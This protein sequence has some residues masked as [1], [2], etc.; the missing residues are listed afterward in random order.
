MEN[1][2][3]IYADGQSKYI[4]CRVKTYRETAIWPLDTTIIN[5]LYR[6]MNKY[7]CTRNMYTR[8]ERTDETNPSGTQLLLKIFV[9]LKT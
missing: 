7:V 8:F 4:T 9:L 5:R 3:N 2:R 6:E 1:V